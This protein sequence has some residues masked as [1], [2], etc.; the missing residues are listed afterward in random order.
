[1]LR[2][3]AAPPRVVTRG[4]ALQPQSENCQEG[5]TCSG[6]LRL[7]MSAGHPAAPRPRDPGTRPSPTLLPPGTCANFSCMLASVCSFP[8]HLCLPPALHSWKEFRFLVRSPRLPQTQVPSRVGRLLPIRQ[9][10]VT[11]LCLRWPGA[12]ED[13]TRTADASA[14]AQGCR[15]AAKV[16]SGRSLLPVL[17]T[18]NSSDEEGQGWAGE[19]AFCLACSIVGKRIVSLAGT[20]AQLPCLLDKGEEAPKGKLPTGPGLP[21]EDLRESS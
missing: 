3:S 12:C 16:A 13:V 2:Y 19:G 5:E 15:E 4:H 17:Q 11:A 20:V 9:L 10:C 6:R 21:P 1:M 7:S 8:I 18:S 14:S